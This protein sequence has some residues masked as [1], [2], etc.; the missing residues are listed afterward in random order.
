MRDL[1]PLFAHSQLVLP[2]SERLL[3]IDAPVATLATS[4]QPPTELP[5]V[6]AD[7]YADFLQIGGQGDR[8]LSK[9]VHLGEHGR[10]GWLCLE[11][12]RG[13]PDFSV[14]EVQLVDLVM[15]QIS[16]WFWPA[17]RRPLLLAQS[18]G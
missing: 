9:S 4:T 1:A 14:D 12:D 7:L 13:D 10:V 16:P 15:Q 17:M 18:F 11:R 6:Q 5:K 8:L 2:H 3:A